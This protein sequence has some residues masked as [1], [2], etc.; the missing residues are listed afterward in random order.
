MTLAE[1]FEDIPPQ[2]DEPDTR[3][4]VWLTAEEIEEARGL[5]SLRSRIEALR[6]EVGDRHDELCRAE[7]DGDTGINWPAYSR[8]VLDRLLSVQEEEKA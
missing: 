8:W 2:K 6:L 1:E 3:F 4:A 5:L 7:T